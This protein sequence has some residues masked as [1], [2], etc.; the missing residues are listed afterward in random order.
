M[1]FTINAA[2]TAQIANL[3]ASLD[4][5]D[6]IYATTLEAHGH[7]PHA[8]WGVTLREPIPVYSDDPEAHERLGR[9]IRTDWGWGFA[10]TEHTTTTV[11]PHHRGAE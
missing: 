8:G 9:I 4:K 5:A 6:A 7:L 1:A 2:Q 3:L 11:T 10:P